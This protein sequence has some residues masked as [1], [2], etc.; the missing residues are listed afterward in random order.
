M[1]KPI[2]LL[3]IKQALKDSRFRDSFPSSFKEDI[4]KYLQNPGCSCN[5]PFYKRIITEGKEYVQKYFPNR[6]LSSIEDDLEKL[7]ENKFKVINCK[8]EELENL[9]KKLPKGRK[10]ISM[11]R[12]K[13]DITV[14]VNELDI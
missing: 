2:T 14:V 8:V 13:N 6:F 12:Y 4:Q 3:D 1:S 10:Q 9:L 5:T 7:P 11:A